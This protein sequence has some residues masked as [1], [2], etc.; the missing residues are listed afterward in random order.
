MIIHGIRRTVHQI[1]MLLLF[2][3]TCR[4]TSSTVL[5]KRVTKFTLF[6]VPLF[7]VAI[8]RWLTC[9][10]CGTSQ[11]ISKPDAEQIQ[12]AQTNQC[13]RVRQARNR[14][15]PPPSRRCPHS[16]GRF[17]PSGNSS[18]VLRPHFTPAS[19]SFP[20]ELMSRS[21]SHIR[22]C[23]QVS[24][25]RRRPFR[26]FHGTAEIARHDRPHARVNGKIPRAQL[27]MRR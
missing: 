16:P 26:R 1:A 7:P 2:C 12:A 15:S 17:P 3:N 8:S 18:R 27:G 5:T 22:G 11:K 24:A 6:F 9:I 20:P 25:N 21:R 23:K 14:S 4:A 10:R 13:T 19:S